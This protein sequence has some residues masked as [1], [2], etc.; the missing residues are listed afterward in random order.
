MT[1]TEAK[2]SAGAKGARRFYSPSEA[3]TR[4]ELEAY[5]L[6]KLRRLLEYNYANNAFYRDLW[7]KHG[8]GP[9]DVQSLADYRQKFPMIEKVDC[10][11]DQA[12][13]PPFGRRLGVPLEAVR[14]V[15]LTSGTSGIGQEAWGLTQSDVELAAT[16][17]L[18]QYHWEGL[19]KGDVAFYSMPVA[20]FANG[21]SAEYAGRKMGMQALNLFGMDKD[22]TFALMERF[23][24]HYVY[25]MM[26]MPSMTGSDSQLPRERFSRVK[27]VQGA[28]MSAETMQKVSDAWGA[29]IYEMYGCTQSSSVV[30]ATCE[31]TAL[32]N[33][34]AGMVHFLESHYIVECLDRETGQP[35][36]PGD[37]TEI[38]LTTLD[39][40]ASPAI[41]FRMHDKAEYMAAG[42]CACGRPYHGYRAGSIGRWDDM[43]KIK[44]INVWPATF[45]DI[46]MRHPE[47]AEYRG[48]VDFA[49]TRDDCRIRL[50]FRPELQLGD[51]DRVR[52]IDELRQEIKAKAFITV[53]IEESPEELP[54]FFFKPV[55]WTDHRKDKKR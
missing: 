18:V 43:M 34:E 2:T 24:P 21:L 11:E 5:Q 29:P 30:A 28:M 19:A 3:L 33:G 44:G 22:L 1:T 32:V 20:F 46:V 47:V 36:D 41:R 37:N 42:Q 13:T 6:R 4:E 35:S 26:A 7:K 9:E 15:N 17:W 38:I 54:G 23:Q 27:A 31:E 8:V 45:D 53:V 40:E 49:G 50:S 12:D 14:Q 51:G 55:R 16:V 10:L 52:F 39:R 48:E 25:G